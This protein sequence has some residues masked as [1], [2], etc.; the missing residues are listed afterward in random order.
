LDDQC[1]NYS[2]SY[3]TPAILGD[4]H[5]CTPGQKWIVDKLGQ[6]S[7]SGTKG[8]ATKVSPENRLI[9]VLKNI[10]GYIKQGKTFEERK[11]RMREKAFGTVVSCNDPN[12]PV[13]CKVDLG[14]IE[15]YECVSEGECIKRY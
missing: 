3:C 2:D 4:R 9:N 14:G 15:S 7:C 12:Y 6:G 5:C 13:C 11:G 1:C 10:T 8:C